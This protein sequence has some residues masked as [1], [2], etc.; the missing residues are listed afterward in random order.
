MKRIRALLSFLSA[1]GAVAAA[2]LQPFRMPW[3]DATPGVTNL[4]SWQPREA[5]ADGW[6]TVSPEGH[7]LAGGQRIRFLGVN[8][9]AGNNF[10]T[11]E[12]AEA[13]AARLARFGFNAVR[14]H[15][16]E[17]PWEKNNVLVDYGMG[18]SRELAADRLD[19]LHYFIAKL[20]E[21]G[22]YSDLNLLVSREF[23]PADGLGPEIAE[24]GWKD[25]QILGFFHEGALE[26]HKEFAA[27]LLTAPNPY[28]GDVP[29]GRD[30]AVAFVE[31]MN[32]NGLLQKWH[33]GVLETMP[34][35][36]RDKLRERWNGWLRAR[37][38][39]QAAMMEAW[40][41]VDQPL[42]ANKL[43]NGDFSNGTSRWNFERHQGALATFSATADFDGKPAL[44]V[45]VTSP[46]SASWHVQ[47]N[48][49]PIPIESGTVLTLS[50]WAKAQNATFIS[51]SVQ[52]AHTDYVSLGPAI[53]VTLGPEWRQYT[54]TW[55]NAAAEDR[56]RVNF[57]GFGDRR[58]VVWL[59]DVRLQ[60]GGQIGAL[61]EGVS[62]AA[63]NVPAVKGGGSGATLGQKKDWV[64]FALELERMYWEEMRR[65]V[66]E[67][68]GYEGIV[69]ATIVS[70]SPPNT[71]EGMDAF[72]SHSY[73][74][75]PSFPA[76]DDWSPVNWT[77]QNVSMVNDRDAGGIGAIAR[78]RVAGRPHNV[79]EYQHPSPNT[80]ASEGPLLIAAYGALQDWDSLWFF[81]YRTGTTEYVSGF[82]D[83]GGH[84]GKMANNLLAAAMFRRFDVA[85][86]MNEWRVAF[87]RSKEVDI[88]AERGRAWNVADGSLA[89]IPATSALVSRVS[90]AIGEEPEGMDEPPVAPEPGEI[91]SDT[92]EL[93]WDLRNANKGV[94]TIDTQRTKAVVGFPASRSFELGNVS[95]RPGETRQGW[96]TIGLT[97]TEGE[98]FEAQEG[99]TVLVVATGD[100]ENTGMVWK[101]EAKNSVGDRWG[102]APV[103][104][105]AVP[106]TISLPVPASRVK[107][108]ALTPAGERAEE[109]AVE[110]S[111]G[112]A[113]IRIGSAATLWYEVRIEAAPKEQGEE[114]EE[115]EE[116]P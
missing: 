80:Y 90:L 62:L 31:I 55:Q 111:D 60:E 64:R 102:G 6:V 29:L 95:I 92:G 14:F 43:V 69:F 93:R 68:L 28:R 104:V 98:S 91:V 106:A 66:K 52:R 76:G 15:H 81:S 107:V 87:S 44:R 21:K 101:S 25:Q 16:M 48:Q 45:E 47:V 63:G 33:E 49:S 70:N 8:T 61:P 56:A 5:G 108:W 113:Q 34:V 7:Y 97:L 75:H 32:E 39:D 46:G 58:A 19:K 10:P 17:A 109:M 18:N 96:C 78:Q 71:Q 22:I 67:D 103:L 65:F 24:M 51:C 72:D 1:L 36:Y 9:E 30:P 84:P 38:A 40:G 94:V 73:W 83:H 20:A 57:N 77:V 2:D 116:T 54:L 114:Q 3:N 59:A 86:A 11:R 112:R 12:R 79:T 27:K 82:F 42:G 110:E 41:A 85:P 88:A 89:G 26:L 50:F 105:E 74:Q 37:Y 115:E 99:A 13:H 100:F 23:Q 53:S 4:Q 35:S